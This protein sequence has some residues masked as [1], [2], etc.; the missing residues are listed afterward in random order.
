MKDLYIAIL[1]LFITINLQAQSIRKPW[2]EF[3]DQE[4]LNYVN[5]INSLTKTQVQE[6]AD[7]HRRLFFSGIHDNNQFLP[8]HRIFLE[9]FENLLQNVND[10]V[11][12]PYW[13]W[14]QSWSTS[15]LLFQDNNGGNTGLLGYDV[16]GS[17]WEDEFNGGMFNRL[18]N[19]SITQ[20]LDSYKNA[21]NFVDFTEW[22]EQNE[23]VS[24]A[25]NKGHRFIG[26]DM[27]QMYSPIDPVFYI[28]HAMVDKAWSD[29]Y[30]DNPNADVSILDDNM[31][32]FQGYPVSSINAENIVNHRDTKLWYAYNNSLILNNY[33]TSGTEKY[34]YTT[35]NI[36]VTDF[37]VSN[38]SK[39]EFIAKP[40]NSIT[41]NAGFYAQQGSVLLAYIETNGTSPSVRLN[42][43]NSLP[44]FKSSQVQVPGKNDESYIEPPTSSVYPNPNNGNFQISIEE[45]Y[46]LEP[47]YYKAVADKSDIKNEKVK[48]EIFNMQGVKVL[49]VNSFTQVNGYYRI[50]TKLNK[51]IYLIR[52]KENEKIMTASRFIV[53]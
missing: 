52:I 6:L 13:N 44:I 22:I 33:S 29:W 21:T 12:I 46:D 39:V 47:N 38:S 9:H 48:I 35:G 23:S 24:G 19:T 25:H 37:V 26:G 50:N 51:G 32:T 45:F 7:E 8:W 17:I 3:T 36:E 18:F 1:L 27:V 15:A 49:D 10:E 4:R 16:N 34:K 14:H 30:N 28:H 11:T 43:D 20:P 42:S 40:D 41:L 31:Q 5:A 2:E 53:E